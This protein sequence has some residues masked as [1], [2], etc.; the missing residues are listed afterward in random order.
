MPDAITC[1]QMLHMHALN[2][3][4]AIIAAMPAT[5]ASTFHNDMRPNQWIRTSK[6]KDAAKNITRDFRRQSCY[7]YKY[8][9]ITYMFYG[10]TIE[11]A[12]GNIVKIEI[13]IQEN[14]WIDNYACKTIWI[15]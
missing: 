4:D 5:I 6:S 11:S 2:N 9:Q 15:G 10:K 14:I 12:A 3:K 13:S 1:K 8:G 7:S